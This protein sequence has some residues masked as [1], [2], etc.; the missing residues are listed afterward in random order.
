L[1]NKRGG[2]DASS[3]HPTAKESPD[4]TFDAKMYIQYIRIVAECD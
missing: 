4:K 2:V 1:A 3:G